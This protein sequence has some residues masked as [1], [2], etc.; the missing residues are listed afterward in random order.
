MGVFCHSTQDR[1]REC[2]GN[3]GVNERR[4]GRERINMMYHDSYVALIMEWQDACA[5]FIENDSKRIDIAGWL[6]IMPFDLLRGKIEGCTGS[7]VSWQVCAA[8]ISKQWFP[9]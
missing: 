3:V 1:F 9:N 5:H 2:R 7:S 8:K 4:R 6:S